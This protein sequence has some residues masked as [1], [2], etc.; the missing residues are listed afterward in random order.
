[1]KT[2]RCSHCGVTLEP[3]LE[4]CPECLRKHT[5][6]EVVRE[7]GPDVVRWLFLPGAWALGAPLAW[8]HF[9]QREWLSAHGLE[10]GSLLFVGTVML[11]PPRFVIS[12]LLKRAKWRE[13]AGALA[14]I[15]GIAALLAGATMLASQLTSSVPASIL[16]GLILFL[17]PLVA[18]PPL[19]EAHRLGTSRR[20]AFGV[21]LA[22]FAGIAAL[23]ITIF[24]LKMLAAPRP[25]PPL[26]IFGNP[27]AFLDPLD[28]EHAPVERGWRVE[29]DGLKTL[30]LA[31]EA[32]PFERA[33]LKLKVELLSALTDLDQT[34]DAAPVVTLWIPERFAT[35]ASRA[36]LKKES[37]LLNDVFTRS[38]RLTP[39]GAPV[40]VVI[41]F[42]ALPR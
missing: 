22:R 9:E 28:L 42:G 37:D 16:I 36:E 25:K 13:A 24:G 33:L 35:D 41:T 1:M 39:R 5:A 6:Q 11:V 21:G 17:A 34:P 19:V 4:R 23:L 14:G 40:R 7:P 12:P 29:A 8:L 31:S 26:V 32:A 3:G 30:H 18:L 2:L 10:V 38:K 20:K 15:W 27:K